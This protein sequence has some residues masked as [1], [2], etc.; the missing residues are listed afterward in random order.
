VRSTLR[1]VP[2]TVPDPFLNHA[3]IHNTEEEVDRMAKTAMIQAQQRWE[4]EVITRKSETYLTRELNGFGEIGW[5]VVAINFGK[6]RK[7]EPAW[8]A[9]LKRPYTGPPRK[10]SV[11]AES[12]VEEADTQ[13][14][15]DP[16]ATLTGFDLE[17]DDFAIAEAG[18]EPEA[19]PGEESE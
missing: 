2:A 10:V 12:A 5:D 15:A 19:I 18:P 13:E 4:Y 6:D 7:G 17:G 1:A 8:H 16:T 3:G 11:E 9:F 14:K